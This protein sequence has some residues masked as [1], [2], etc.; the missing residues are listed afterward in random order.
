LL[1]WLQLNFGPLFFFGLFIEVCQGFINQSLCQNMVLQTFW[2]STQFD[3]TAPNLALVNGTLKLG[4]KTG[5]T[6]SNWGP[7]TG[8]L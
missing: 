1:F 8:R 3:E 5:F 2:T 6:W 4:I 7:K